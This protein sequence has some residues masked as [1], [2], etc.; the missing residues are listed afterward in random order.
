MLKQP[1][2]GACLGTA[3]QF[4][5]IHSDFIGGWRFEAS[6]TGVVAGTRADRLHLCRE[7]KQLKASHQA[8]AEL[9][10]GIQDSST[11]ARIVRA[12]YQAIGKL[13]RMENGQP[14]GWATYYL[15]AILAAAFQINA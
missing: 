9:S 6:G 8:L 10:I 2:M 15:N 5:S 3:Y 11:S 12:G 1:A 14:T 13:I 4:T 7:P